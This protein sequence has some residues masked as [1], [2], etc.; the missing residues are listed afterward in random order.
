M[1]EIYVFECLM[2]GHKY[3]EASEYFMDF[4]YSQESET[5]VLVKKSLELYGKE[6]HETR[7]IKCDFTNEQKRS[8]VYENIKKHIAAGTS[9]NDLSVPK[10]D[11]NSRILSQAHKQIKDYEE[12]MD[13]QSL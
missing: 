3:Y 7:M 6:A 9:L 8:I 13:L 10:F 4:R 12:L 1:F 5:P 11:E 2:T